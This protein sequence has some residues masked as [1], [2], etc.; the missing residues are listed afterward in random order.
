[1]S[2]TVMIQFQGNPYSNKKVTFK[3]TVLVL[4]SLIVDVPFCHEDEGGEFCKLAI[5]IVV[6]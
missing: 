1:M 3:F 4:L 2:L 6:S 5:L